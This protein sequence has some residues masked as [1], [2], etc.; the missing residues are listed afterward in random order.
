M[1]CC[2]N[3][4]ADRSMEN[5]IETIS[6]NVGDCSFCGSTSVK[7]V[8]SQGLADI[9][10]PVLDM[11]VE[12]SG[13]DGSPLPDT[14]RKDWF[15]FENIGN[16]VCFEILSSMYSGT[17]FKEKNYIPKSFPDTKHIDKWNAFREE[18]KHKNRYFPQQMPDLEH[19]EN[20]ISLLVVPEN[21][22]PK[23]M[24]RA[25]C[26]GDS[27][28]LSP[29]DMG[30]PPEKNVSSGRANPIGIPYL[31]TASDIH[32]AIA[33]MRP[34]KSDDIFVARFEVMNR[35]FLADLRSPRKTVSPFEL[36]EEGLVDIEYLCRLG[37]ELSKPVLPREAHL[38]YLPTQYLCEFIKHR[39]FDGIVYKSSVA[40]G[41]NYAIFKDDKLKCMEVL[42]YKITDIKIISSKN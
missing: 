7:V 14:L 9:F 39:G 11:Y 24:F 8:D 36:G 32:T 20:L 16:E 6:Q 4:F 27:D 22:R 41:D 23:E 25:R 33:E 3:C 30:K 13:E 15:I 29:G 35:L 10:Q 5:Y 21:K 18:L 12:T 37:E 38:E 17:N 34:Y 19:L 1:F 31:Y 2:G 40:D 42:S 28:T 26:T